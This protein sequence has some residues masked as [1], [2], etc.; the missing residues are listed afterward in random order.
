M[1]ILSPKLIFYICKR[2]LLALFTILLVIT[3]TFFVM[4]AV[5]GGPFQK[6]KALYAEAQA[7]MVISK[8]YFML[9]LLLF[10]DL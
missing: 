5:P 4:N 9:V 10:Y 1:N 7:A 8:V 2:V 3:I 6:E